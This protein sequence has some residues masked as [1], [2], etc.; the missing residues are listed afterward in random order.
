[1]KLEQYIKE[2]EDAARIQKSGLQTKVDWKAVRSVMAD[3]DFYTMSDMA[4]LTGLT[5]QY[6]YKRPPCFRVVT[7]LGRD[8]F[9]LIE[10][11]KSRVL[12][13]FKSIGFE[14]RSKSILQKGGIEIKFLD[15]R[16]VRI[17][18]FDQKTSLDFSVVADMHTSDLSEISAL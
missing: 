10:K 9:Q 1:M 8:F 12:E 15:D 17:S 3:Y 13:H 14:V 18:F 5:R 11:D 16:Y 7:V 4:R 6:V 2:V